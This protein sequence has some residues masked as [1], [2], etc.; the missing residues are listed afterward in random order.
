MWDESLTGA[1]SLI[2]NP[3]ILKDRN[4]VKMFPIKAGDLPN[5]D[6]RNFIFISRPKI[7][8]MNSIASN[9]HSDEKK[10]R[11]YRK[12]FYLYFLPKKSL[13]CENQLKSKGVFGSFQI[14]DDF[15]CYLFPFEK[16]LLSMENAD[17]FKELY[18]EGDL[19]SLYQSATALCRLQKLYG[20]IN[21][22]AGMGKYAEKVKEL[23][24]TMV[25]NENLSFEKS[26]IDQLIIVDRSIDN[27]SALATQLTYEGLIDEFYGINNTTAT[28]PAE[29]F[30]AQGVDDVNFNRTPSSDEK[31]QI[32]LNSRDELYSDIRDKNFNA[33]GPALS[34][35]AKTITDAANERHGDKTI[36]ELKRIVEKLPKF[37]ATE[38]SFAIH[39]TIASLIKEHISQNDFL[40]ELSCEQD[41]MMCVDLDKSKEFI[42]AMICNQKPITKVLRLIC[43]QSVAG[44]GLK[45]KVL[46]GYKREFIHAYGIDALLKFGKLE[47]AGLIRVQ[48]G[49]RSYNILRKTLN[50]TVEDFHEVAPKDI[51]YVHSFYAPLLIRMIE[52]SLKPLGWSGLNDILSCIPEPLFEDYQISNKTSRRD[53]LTSEM[54]QSDSSKVILVFF[55]GGCTHA[56]VSALRFLAQQEE[57][58]VEFI[59]ATTKLINKRNF[60]S[61]I[62]D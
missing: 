18:I 49:S 5:V 12:N 39:T 43:M 7:N 29:N 1:M 30:T 45:Q 62:I 25:L 57:N 23:S 36:Q 56:E 28:F 2:A 21:K 26:A 55:I 53:S 51:S 3:A 20:K 33:I 42:E 52:S 6:V 47:K 27:L 54:S 22:I 44:G 19:T 48:T 13:L 46:D 24:K 60:L 32:V 31:K 50:L 34:R 9:I 4:V 17:V 35:V 8:I 41:F 59:I 14:I 10:N 61:S 37:K 11:I 58:N 40:D 38:F 15:K 16:D